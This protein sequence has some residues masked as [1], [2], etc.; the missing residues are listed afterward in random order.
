[1]EVNS[2]GGQGS[3]RAVAPS[4]DESKNCVLGWLQYRVKSVGFFRLNRK[5]WHLHEREDTGKQ[6][7]GGSS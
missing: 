6:Y 5:S 7:C 3:R 1:V 4:D 2:A